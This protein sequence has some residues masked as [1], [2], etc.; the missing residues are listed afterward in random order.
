MAREGVQHVGDQQFLVLLF[1]M[2]AK[3]NQRPRVLVRTWQ[4]CRHRVIDVRP[5]VRDP[6]GLRPG[7]QTTHGPRMAGTHRLVVRIKQ[8]AEIVVEHAIILSRGTQDKLFEKPGDMRPVPFH[9][10]GVGH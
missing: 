4:V 9:R 2:Q 1:V 7:Q 3:V 10:T 8:E 6:R 5:V